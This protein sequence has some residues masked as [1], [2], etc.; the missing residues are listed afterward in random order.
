MPMD[1]LMLHAVVKTLQKSLT[2]GRVDRV[3]QPERD[4]IILTIRAQGENQ[5]ILF[6]SN[7]NQARMHRT[8][9]RKKNAE[10][11][12]QFCMLLRKHLLGAKFVSL[13]QKQ[14]LSD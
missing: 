2:G 3:Q 14:N 1:G 8:Y 11:P 5:M 10:T 12:P 9:E 6:S 4:E 7:A 13:F